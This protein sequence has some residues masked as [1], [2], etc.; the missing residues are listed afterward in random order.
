MLPARP[1]HAT[2]AVC[3][4]SPF[5]RSIECVRARPQCPAPP[6]PHAPMSEHRLDFNARAA[7]AIHRAAQARSGQPAP[8]PPST[9]PHML[10]R[11][12][13]GSFWTPRASAA[14]NCPAHAPMSVRRLDFDA[15]RQRVRAAASAPGA[16]RT[17]RGSRNIA[18]HAVRARARARGTGSGTGAGAGSG[19]GVLR[20]KK[21]NGLITLVRHRCFL[22]P[23]LPHACYE[24]SVVSIHLHLPALLHLPR[25]RTVFYSVD[26]HGISLNTLYSCCS[27]P[28]SRAKGGLVV[29][30]DAEGVLF[31]VW[32]ADSLQRSTRGG[33]Y[34]GGAFRFPSLLRRR[35][36]PPPC[37]R[38]HECAQVRC[39]RSTL[40]LPSTAPCTPAAAC[41]TA[42]VRF[43]RPRRRRVPPARAP[44]P[45]PALAAFHC[46]VH[47]L[48]WV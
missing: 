12:C 17:R 14:P 46:P 7:A 36:L 23:G 39:R 13:S 41:T 21:K 20:E 9:C 32:V 18:L 16:A 19:V 47:G 28:A 37:A 33:Y 42:W 24:R 4:S 1:L 38:S 3:T 15:A 26:Q 35:R 10:H 30:Q 48:T 29:I 2:P 11:A 27:A 31:G 40:P 22:Y 5:T 44:A 45:P 8:P 43:R 25:Q 6:P 34:G